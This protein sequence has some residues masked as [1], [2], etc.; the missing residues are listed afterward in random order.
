MPRTEPCRPPSKPNTLLQPEVSGRRKAVHLSPA[1]RRK[2]LAL[3]DPIRQPGADTQAAASQSGAR[4][5][6]KLSSAPAHALPYTLQDTEANEP[7][8]KSHLCLPHF[9]PAVRP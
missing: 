7:H 5:L 1:R 8:E 9:P 2:G 4:H 6:S 3:R